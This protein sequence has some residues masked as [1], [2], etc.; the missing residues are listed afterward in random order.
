MHKFFR[1]PVVLSGDY[2]AY[3]GLTDGHEVNGWGWGAIWHKTPSDQKVYVDT[4]S[5]NSN[6]THISLSR[7]EIAY[8]AH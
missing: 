3:E 4:L 8:S 6:V 1:S 2:K 7:K 5:F